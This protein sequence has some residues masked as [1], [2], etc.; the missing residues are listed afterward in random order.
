MSGGISKPLALQLAK[1][2]WVA[3]LLIGVVSAF[4]DKSSVGHET[5]VGLVF[6][7]V[8]AVLLLMGLACGIAALAT[9]RRFGRPG[10]LVPSVIGVTLSTGLLTLMVFSFTSA[11]LAQRPIRRIAAIAAE[12]NQDLPKMVATDV[13]LTSAKAAGGELIVQY[14]L[15]HHKATQVNA[16][17][18]QAEVAPKVLELACNKLDIPWADGIRTRVLYRSADGVQLA[19]VVVSGQDCK[20]P[21]G[22]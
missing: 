19:E 2:S 15:P 4:T 20:G 17:A 16:S 12:V 13:E 1:A 21:S 10:I 9:V 6:I 22:T 3:V 18:F 7:V 8:A 11:L 5:V 14:T